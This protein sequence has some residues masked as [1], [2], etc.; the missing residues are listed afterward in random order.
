[1]ALNGIQR[2]AYRPDLVDFLGLTVALLSSLNLLNIH[3]QG[4]DRDG[5]DSEEPDWVPLLRASTSA[6][7]WRLNRDFVVKYSTKIVLYANEMRK[8]LYN[9]TFCVTIMVLM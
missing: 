1:M 6:R 7:L 8:R 2:R 5:E 9:K 3:I 4:D